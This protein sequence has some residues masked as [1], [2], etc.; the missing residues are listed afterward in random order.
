LIANA[1]SRKWSGFDDAMLRHANY[2]AYASLVAAIT[3]AAKEKTVRA[4]A[5]LALVVQTRAAHSCC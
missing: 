2:I 5:A 3:A 1:A 4:L